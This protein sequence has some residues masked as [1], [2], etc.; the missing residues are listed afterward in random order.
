VFF[1]FGT[2]NV[3]PKVIVKAI[4]ETFDFSVQGI[5]D[6]L[7]LTQPVFFR[8]SKYGHFGKN[9]FA[10]EKLDKVDALRKY[11]K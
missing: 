1:K 7:S 2:E 5:I 11:L 9:E 4:N 6:H 10:W 8:T 3:D